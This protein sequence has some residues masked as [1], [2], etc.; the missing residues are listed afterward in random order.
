MDKRLFSIGKFLV[1]TTDW[2]HWHLYIEGGIEPGWR[3]C[4][5]RLRIDYFSKGLS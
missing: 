5:G 2:W 3:L 4:I 1:T